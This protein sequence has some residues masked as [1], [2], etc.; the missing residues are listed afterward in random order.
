MS[1]SRFRIHR[2]ATAS[3][4]VALLALPV[5]AHADDARPPPAPANSAPVVTHTY[6]DAASGQRER[7]ARFVVANWFA[8]DRRAVEAGLFRSY[9]LLE[10]PRVDEDWDLI[11]EVVYHD[12]CGYPC[13][14]ARFEALR[15]EHATVAIDGQVMPALGR[16]V[17]SVSFQ[18][19]EGG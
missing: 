5:A 11:V 15:A 3:R 17:R 6:L 10:N 4:L 16:V 2:A 13:V 12:A 8:I 7:L 19:R 1:R 18:P 14:A 9:R